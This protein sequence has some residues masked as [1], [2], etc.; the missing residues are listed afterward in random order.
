MLPAVL[1]SHPWLRGPGLAAFL[2]EDYHC[3]PLFTEVHDGFEITIILKGE[4]RFQWQE[5]VR[6]CAPGEVALCP[7]WEPHG[8]RSTVPGTTFISFHFLPELFGN[9]MLAGISW[10]RLFSCDPRDRP[11]TPPTGKGQ[12]LAI[13]REL[14]RHA[15]E[16]TEKLRRGPDPL[17]PGPA[18]SAVVAVQRAMYLGDPDLPAT[19]KDE[20]RLYLLL[21]LLKLREGWDGTAGLNAQDGTDQ[22]H[23]ARL[24]PALDLAASQLRPLHRTTVSEAAGACS[25]S[26]SHF[27]DLF[28]D[29]M[30]VSFGQ[31]ELR[32]R[33]GAAMNMLV[34]TDLSVAEIAEDCGF[35]DSRHLRREL[36]KH[37]GATPTGIREHP[38]ASLR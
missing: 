4:R 12:V 29:T 27:R 11:Q 19:W 5:H 8:W 10:L 14:A 36:V 22:T 21:L 2:R 3:Y 38:S 1:V 37:C 35:T 7:S 17:T 9:E 16:M 13:A 20:V 28:R 31:F 30:G 24:T 18:S 32:R 23:L 33:L 15:P 26:T 25:L 6:D 34:N